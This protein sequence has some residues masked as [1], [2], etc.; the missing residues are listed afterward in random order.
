MRRNTGAIPW[1]ADPA[2]VVAGWIKWHGEGTV[3]IEGSENVSSL[4]DNAAGDF[5]VTWLRSFAGA[6]TYAAMISHTG[7]L[8]AG[9]QASSCNLEDQTATTVR[10]DTRDYVGQ[11]AND[12]DRYFICAVGES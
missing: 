10:T 8:A 2:V 9:T 3:T 12:S 6:S 11:T 7:T 1:M 5:T 4:T